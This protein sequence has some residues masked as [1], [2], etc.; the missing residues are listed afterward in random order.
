MFRKFSALAAASSMVLASMAWAN[1]PPPLPQAADSGT[2]AKMQ[3]QCDLLA[4]SYDNG[5]GDIWKGYVVV[6]APQ[7]SSGPTEVE[8]T[9]DV[10]PGSIQP[11][12]TL[13]LTD[14]EI[15][16]DPFRIGGSVNLFG[17]QIANG[18]TYPGSTYNFTAEYSTT[19][20]FA[21][22][23]DITRQEYIPPVQLPVQGYYVNNGTNPSGGEGSCQGF[24]PAMHFWG[25]DQGNCTFVKTG[26]AVDQPADWGPEMTVYTIAG[27]PVEQEQT[28][29]LEGFEANGGPV[30]VEGEYVGT[31]VICIS[32][33][34]GASKKGVPGEWRTQ[35]GY[36]G[37]KCTTE[38]FK[39]APWG[40]GT[41]G[42]QGT[43][44]SVPNYYS[45]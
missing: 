29:T 40:A 17:K 21:F 24:T 14:P 9:R 20:A 27:T 35:N 32:P 11:T 23:C 5:N 22:D 2:L 3:E 15:D 1:V 30:T 28:D 42:S 41:D 6:G 4:D 10:I 19:F 25:Q 13:V 31:V 44:I 8:D 43:F 26:D 34:T 16:G 39:V 36:T 33:S 45:L 38:W 12:G 7:L 37:D 18:G